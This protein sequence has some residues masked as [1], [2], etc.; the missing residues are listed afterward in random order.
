[1]SLLSSKAL[2][3]FNVHPVIF[4]CLVSCEEDPKIKWKE[5]ILEERTAGSDQPCE[6]VMTMM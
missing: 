6:L 2:L 3:H 1:M 4:T 5:H